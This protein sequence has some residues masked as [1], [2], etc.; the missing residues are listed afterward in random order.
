M[1][2]REYYEIYK[3]IQD[4]YEL[5]EDQR[6]KDVFLARMQC[7]VHCDLKARVN[8]W[9][10]D[11]SVSENTWMWAGQ[12]KAMEQLKEC[13]RDLTELAQKGYKVLLYGTG[14]TAEDLGRM[15]LKEEIPFF[16]FC[17]RKQDTSGLEFMGKP[18]VSH[19]YLMEH[20]SE[21]YLIVQTGIH[22]IK[23]MERLKKWQFPE[24]RILPHYCGA[25]RYD[26]N[27]VY[28]DFPQFFQKGT[29]FVDG[30]CYNGDTSLKFAKWCNGEYSTIFAFE[31][32]P[33]NV[34]LC[35]QTFKK[36]GLKN[37]NFH[38]AGLGKTNEVLTFASGLTTG[39][40]I[41]DETDCPPEEATIERI[42]IVSLDDVVGDEVVG[43][44]K[45]DI[46]GAEY[47]ALEGA[48]RTIARDKPLLAIC[49]Y[50]KPGDQLALMDYLHSLVPEYRFWL[51]HYGNRELETILYA[52]V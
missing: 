20:I 21:C 1:K 50:H 45:L 30:G 37:V 2:M 52:A 22:Y 8:L 47:D 27:A 23:A 4:L 13:K 39:S 44:I 31:P 24:E 48:Q 16:G 28:F 46:E 18:V 29:A 12:E 14:E 36:T 26:W 34:V 25:H 40:R 19:A 15:F 43:F 3:K 33:Q 10:T 42:N 9:T 49:V 32:D 11:S 51:R 38:P 35:E 5:L 7:D 17:S 6:S 41:V